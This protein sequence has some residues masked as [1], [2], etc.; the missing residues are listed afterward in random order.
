MRMW[1]AAS[2]LW[3]HNNWWICFSLSSIGL[4]LVE[5]K[6]GCESVLVQYALLMSTALRI[7]FGS[8]GCQLCTDLRWGDYQ[9][10]QFPLGTILPAGVWTS[11]THSTQSAHY[12]VIMPVLHAHLNL[13][14][15]TFEK[16]THVN[17]KGFLLMYCSQ[18]SLSTL[19]LRMWF[20]YGLYIKQLL[21]R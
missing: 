20:C 3:H 4:L 2:E 14:C 5:V 13:N 10:L 1:R 7:S 6:N 18:L 21:H 8:L 12:P 11:Y 9:F 15:S 17:Y 19:L 16:V